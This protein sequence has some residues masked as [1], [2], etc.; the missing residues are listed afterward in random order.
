MQTRQRMNARIVELERARPAANRRLVEMAGPG[1]GRESSAPNGRPGSPG[2]QKI[3]L[4]N[5]LQNPEV[6]DGIRAQSKAQNRSNLPDMGR[7]VG[8][9]AQEEDHLL[10]LLAT[11]HIKSLEAS[12]LNDREIAAAYRRAD[13]ELEAALLALLNRERYARYLDY[14]TTFHERAQIRILRGMLSTE[15]ALADDQSSRLLTILRHERERVTNE[16][17]QRSR[18]TL[19]S[20]Q[21]RR[22]PANVFSLEEA[23]L[24]AREE[25]VL[26]VRQQ[27]A[28]VLSP[29]QCRQLDQLLEARLNDERAT[30]EYRRVTRNLN[31]SQRVTRL[32][33]A[34]TGKSP[35]K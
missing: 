26:R 10:D 34:P 24:R 11:H 23:G 5:R 8:L 20:G 25:S 1:R 32:R 18:Q 35:E 22:E 9:S 7:V 17:I 29:E 4:R 3:E 16:T 28:Q 21:T 31:T 6:R 12:T 33:P 14:Q 2:H 30:L 15:N 13:Q 19:H 27:A